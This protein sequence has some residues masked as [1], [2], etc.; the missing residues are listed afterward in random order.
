[1]TDRIF[2][3]G[4]MFRIPSPKAPDWVKGNI[5]INTEKMI[6]FLKEHPGENGWINLDVK[7]SKNGTAYVE[8]STFVPKIKP[9]EEF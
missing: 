4:M 6:N 2:V 7:L 8:L 3:D 9:K 1:M 5:S